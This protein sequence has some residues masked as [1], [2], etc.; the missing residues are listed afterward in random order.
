MIVSAEDLKR[1][2]EEAIGRR[3]SAIGPRDAMIA[4][5]ACGTVQVV[6]RQASRRSSHRRD[7]ATHRTACR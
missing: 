1:S 5:A 2:L 6:A 4:R 3:G 7:I